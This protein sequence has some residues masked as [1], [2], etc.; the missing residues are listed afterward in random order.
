RAASSRAGSSRPPPAA[1]PMCHR[2]RSRMPC[3]IATSPGA[4]SARRRSIRGTPRTSWAA[5][6]AGPSCR[7]GCSHSA[8]YKGAGAGRH[9]PRPPTAVGRAGGVMASLASHFG[10]GFINEVR[11]YVSRDRSDASGFLELPEGRVQ[12]GSDLAGSGRGIATL[13]FGGNPGF[14]QHTDNASGEVTE[15]LSWLSGGAAHRL[16][17]GAYASGARLRAVQAPNQYGTYVFQ[18]L[19]ALASDRPAQFT[20]TLAPLEQA[21][22]GWNGALYLGDIWRTGNGVQLTYG[23]RLEAARFSGAPAF[24]PAIDSLF[25]MRTDRIPSEVHVSPRIGF[26]WTLGGRGGVGPGG[27]TG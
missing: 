12:V 16:K 5:V 21:G 9:W 17:L 25:G 4:A 11:G 23:T 1:A 7:T 14:P 15:E 10:A 18:S 3:A 27:P 13:A 22:T 6:S 26:T 19:D 20:R 8:R 24:N 2:G